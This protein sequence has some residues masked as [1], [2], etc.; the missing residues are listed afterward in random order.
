MTLRASAS[1]EVKAS[2][3]S[4]VNKFEGR[5]RTLPQSQPPPS[6]P[7]N[8]RLTQQGF[9]K[10]LDLEPSYQ[11]SEPTDSGD[12]IGDISRVIVE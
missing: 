2:R 8:Q 7:S 4:D 6:V 3:S 11:T 9:P 12:E 1:S 5:H 10:F